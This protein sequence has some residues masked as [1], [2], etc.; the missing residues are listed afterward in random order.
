VE[1][2]ASARGL[3]L[4]VYAPEY[5]LLQSAAWFR[6]ILSQSS[7]ALVTNSSHTLLSAARAGLG[8][9]VLPSFMSCLYDDLVCV[10][11]VLFE[12]HHWLV[13]HPAFRRDPKV[14]ALAGFLK[15]IARGPGGL[16]DGVE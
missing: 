9:A 11:D 7:L 12:G 8:L 4:L 3:P 2:F 13:L 14:R 10:S 5:Q 16:D 15:R 6:P 1:D